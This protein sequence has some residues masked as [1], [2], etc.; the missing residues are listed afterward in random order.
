[1]IELHPVADF[2]R[3]AD[4][5]ARAVVD[6]EIVAD[7]GAGVDVDAGAAVRPLAHHSRD[8]RN[9]QLVQEMGEPVDGDGLQAGIAEDHLVQ[10]LAGGVAV[11]GRLHIHRQNLA[12]VGQL[13]EKLHRLR[14]ADGL[15]VARLSRVAWPFF[16][17]SWRMA[18]P[19]CEVSVS[20]NR[21]IRSPTW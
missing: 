9:V 8:Q 12:Q 11:V 4:H 18:R 19:I 3:F 15:E 14:L 5:H 2:G 13:F 6:E 10:R 17:A 20:C 1:M 21:S 7:R 16:M